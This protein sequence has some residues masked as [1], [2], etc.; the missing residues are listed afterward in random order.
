[1][2]ELATT[3]KWRFSVTSVTKTKPR[4]F[5][6][7]T[8]QLSAAAATT[9]STTPTNSPENTLACLSSS[10]PPLKPPLSATSAR[11]V[12]SRLYPLL[13]SQLHC[14]IY[15]IKTPLLLQEGRAFV[16][17]QQD[18]AILCRDCDVS[19]HTANDHTKNHNR[20]LL[21]GIKVTGF[22]G[23]DAVADPKPLS[24]PT[25]TLKPSST[26]N[27]SLKKDETTEGT[28]TISEYLIETLPGWQF[29]DFLASSAPNGFC[30]VGSNP[31]YLFYFICKNP[32]L[33]C[34]ISEILFDYR[35]VLILRRFSKMVSTAV[36]LRKIGASTCLKHHNRHRKCFWIPISILVH[37]SVSRLM[38]LRRLG[39]FPAWK[40]VGNWWWR[41]EL[42]T[43]LLFH[44]SGP[45]RP[46]DQDLF[47]DG[48]K[49]KS[50]RNVKN[51]TTGEVVGCVSFSVGVFVLFGWMCNMESSDM[52]RPRRCS[53]CSSTAAAPL[54]LLN[55]VASGRVRIINILTITL[56]AVVNA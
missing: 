26:T 35:L 11:L 55:V 14:G 3:F 15:H 16:F 40:L 1:M 20:F 54:C 27:S 21:T 9:A 2:F 36:S 18:R 37:K 39:K 56:K 47:G 52:W 19:I 41:R 24:V 7:P 30:E 33:L 23:C 50:Y 38:G 53:A 51:F 28:S 45:Y 6:P 22:N 17:C 29:E 34:W 8:R 5:A 13:F 44:R 46:R 43:L 10:L 48:V 25:E 4:C 49:I 42:T 31:I 12:L 32:S